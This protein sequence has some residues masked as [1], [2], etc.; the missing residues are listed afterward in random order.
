[1]CIYYVQRITKNKTWSLFSRGLYYPPGGRP[2]PK[3]IGTKLCPPCLSPQVRHLWGLNLCMLKQLSGSCQ[4]F[5]SNSNNIVTLLP[6][7]PTSCSW[8]ALLHPF[9]HIQFYSNPQLKWPLLHRAFSSLQ[10]EQDRH[11]GGAQWE[12]S[13]LETGELE[14]ASQKI[15]SITGRTPPKKTIKYYNINILKENIGCNFMANHTGTRNDLI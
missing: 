6:T 1:M 7:H 2:A 12:V 4:S 10:P 5:S 14:Q 15:E 8:N 3:T 9:L 13:F 11:K